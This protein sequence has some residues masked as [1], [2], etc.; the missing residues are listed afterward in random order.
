[1]AENESLVSKFEWEKK[2]GKID[3]KELQ[4]AADKI[5]TDPKFKD[6]V[7]KGLEI[8]TNKDALKKAISPLL[9]Q[10]LMKEDLWK[11]QSTFTPQQKE[12]IR[13]L[14]NLLNWQET[15][16]KK[17][18]AWWEKSPMKL[19][20]LWGNFWK[21]KEV[22][23]KTTS[24]HNP[25]KIPEAIK[26]M[27]GLLNE[28][29]TKTEFK[30]II[31]EIEKSKDLKDNTL[32]VYFIES[33]INQAVKK[34]FTI[35]DNAD[36]E[37][38]KKSP[39]VAELL[40]DKTPETLLKKGEKMI[41][42][43]QDGKIIIEPVLAKD[44]KW[45]YKFAN[46]NFDQFNLKD[47]V[48][49]AVEKIKQG[50]ASW[51]IDLKNLWKWVDYLLKSDSAFLKWLGEFFK[52]LGTMFGFYQEWEKPTEIKKL[53]NSDKISLL[54]KMFDKNGQGYEKWDIEFN[55]KKELQKQEDSKTQKYIADVQQLLEIREVGK[56]TKGKEMLVYWTETQK[57]VIELQQ[58]LYPWDTE[59]IKAKHTGKF[60]AQTVID[61][62]TSLEPKKQEPAPQAPAAKVEAKAEAPKTLTINWKTL[63]NGDS[64]KLS[65]NIKKSAILRKEN[66]DKD[67]FAKKDDNI[68][69][70]LSNSQVAKTINIGGKDH[71]CL[72]VKI[73]D[74]TSYLSIQVLELW[75][76]E[77]KP[78][79]KAITKKTGKAK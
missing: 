5:V 20:K 27:E 4:A 53:S 52:F 28:P 10:P 8:P 6:E 34:G 3:Q 68:T 31:A 48:A 67:W 12:W 71:Q 13:I 42:I 62:K 51:T 59:E 75:A 45:L 56:D 64:L 72:P 15:I 38:L 29:L 36:I 16:E 46:T 25:N 78:T 49:P 18:A 32:V 60:D 58:K 73:W 1:M 50:I 57:K 14:D 9:N 2:D 33:T 35:E 24:E 66:W 17:L 37:L 40:K 79:P 39:K 65:K 22:I 41:V 70:D 30:L 7:V 76:T 74:K 54:W 77:K 23:N 61:Y 47:G 19:I 26:E 43:E 69:L 21:I 11:D 63:S 55:D 44:G